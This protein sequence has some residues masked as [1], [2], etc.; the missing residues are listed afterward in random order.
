MNRPG[1]IVTLALSLWAASAGAAD[2]W[3]WWEGEQPAETNFPNAT[4]FSASTFQDKREKVLSGGDWLCN[5]DNR[6]AGEA[7]AFAK[8]KVTVPKDGTYKFWT[9][10][11]WK[12]GPFKWRF[13]S[14]PWQECG[15]DC[16][17][18]DS[19]EIRLHLGANWVYLGET[20]LTA[21]EQTCEIV[22]LAKENEGKT[23]CF[24]CFLLIPGAF[25][26]RGKLKPGQTSGLAM[27][28]YF[29]FEPPNDDFRA[30]ALFDL[31]ELNEKETGI[32]GHLKI[33]GLNFVNA[34][35][36]PVKLWSVQAGIDLDDEALEYMARRLAKNGVNH[37]RVDAKIAEL[38]NADPTAYDKKH[39]DRLH[40]AAAAFKKNG[41]YMYFGHVFWGNWNINGGWGIAGYDGKKASH[42]IVMF[43]EKMEQIYRGWVKT[44]LTSKNPYTGLALKDDPVV[45]TF[46]IQN[47]D[48][49]LFWTFP[50]SL[51][52][53]AAKKLGKMYGDWLA[54]K[55]GSLDKARAAWGEGK[56]KNDD[57]A[58]GVLAFIGPWQMTTQGLAQSKN[59][60]ARGSDQLQ[61][62]TETQRAFYDRTV[63]YIKQDLGAKC[64][65]SCSNWTTA[66]GR[67]MDAMERYTYLAGDVVCRNSYFGPVY[68]SKRKRFYAVDTDEVFSSRSGL[69]MPEDLPIQLNQIDE[70]PYVITEIN[71]ERPNRFR[72][73][74]PFLAASYG[75]LQ[76]MDGWNFF[77]LGNAQWESNPSVWSLMNP[78]LFGMFPACSLMFRRGDVKEAETVVHQS[79]DLQEQYHYKGMAL[80]QAHGFDELRK[81]DI[82]AGGVMEG[83][84]ISAIDPLAFYVGRCVFDTKGEK[85]KN[86]VIDLSKYIDREKKTVASVTGEVTWDYDTG[87]VTVNT[88]RAQG[89][90]GFLGKK[91]KIDLGDLSI[92][93]ENEYACVLAI[94]L[95][96][97][98][99][100]SSKK[101]LIQAVT[102]D[103]LYGWKT[104]PQE[105]GDKI[106]DLGGYPLNVKKIKAKVTFKTPGALKDAV[107]ADG[108]AYPTGKNA[109]TSATGGALTVTLPE[110]QLYTV[111]K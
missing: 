4:P 54:K 87:V 34:K 84:D 38:D 65:V 10:K 83:K 8:Y 21:G 79:L 32:D 37:V 43:D 36:E 71:W 111:L 14:Q 1:M 88:A 90:C 57:W 103:T 85:T 48:S 67:I 110:D 28:G 102:E 59:T 76:G 69:T 94:S 33:D 58:A 95:D 31:R 12:H 92:E 73:E 68:H 78:S 20:K 26:P 35:G 24:D 49:F 55:Y 81:K 22:L 93:C 9:R 105:K 89:A 61:F 98:P 53:E 46:E 5:A 75:R 64:L 11:F 13:G 52:P 51:S 86:K 27:D 42:A 23:A 104:V 72:C 40:R 6:K 91:G 107:I 80:K 50:K 70:R 29:A 30:E 41:I 62:L 77:A 97:Q 7:E 25:T 63:K 82:P 18:A 19:T 99:L 60:M 45:A 66:D 108:N 44:I 74:F 100:K 109:A 56:D 17:L 96:G 106:V 2:D 16:A 39:L 3:V 47:E 15:R 101:I